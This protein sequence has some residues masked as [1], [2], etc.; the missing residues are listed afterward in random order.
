MWPNPQ[1][2]ADLVSLLEKFLI[3]NFIFCAVKRTSVSFNISTDC[4]II[5]MHY[6]EGFDVKKASKQ[7]KGLSKIWKITKKVW[8]L[9]WESCKINAESWMPAYKHKTV[10]SIKHLAMIKEYYGNDKWFFRFQLCISIKKWKL[11]NLNIN[12]CMKSV[13]IRSFF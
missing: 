3:K 13:Q 5:W 10:F 8:S 6:N 2:P 11:F 1:F 9:P 4:M 7:L 12:Y